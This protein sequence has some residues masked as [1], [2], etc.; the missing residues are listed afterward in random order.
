[1]P[2]A[3]DIMAAFVKRWTARSFCLNWDPYWVYT[4]P[5]KVQRIYWNQIKDE[6]HLRR[7]SNLCE[8]QYLR[9]IEETRSALVDSAKAA[10]QNWQVL[11]MEFERKLCRTD[12]YWLCL[13]YTSPRPTRLGMI[14]YA[15]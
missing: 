4:S 6:N 13:L 7:M 1:M 12:L 9:E 8:K 2:I 3:P 14:S 5:K 10:G 11:G 15:V